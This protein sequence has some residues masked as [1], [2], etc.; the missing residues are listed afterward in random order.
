MQVSSPSK[1]FRVAADVGGTFTDIVAFD[2]ASGGAFYGKTLTTPSQLVDGIVTGVN[3]ARTSVDRARLF[4][5]GTTIAINTMLERSGARTALLTTRGFRD[6]YEIGRINRPQAYNLFF[7]KHQPLIKRSLRF[8]VNERMNARG[9]VLKALDEAELVATAAK[10]R[11]LEIEAVAIL[12]FH[13]YVNPAHELRAKQVIEQNCPGVFVSASHELS[14][15]YREFERTSTV[16]ANAYIGPRIKTYLGEI[17]ERFAAE[18]FDGS[19][20]V[21]QS[22]GGLFDVARAQREC[23]R[24]LESGPAAGVIGSKVVCDRLGLRN[25]IAFDMGG[26]TAKAGVVLAGEV[27]MAGNIMVGGYAEGL[28]IQIP[29]ID[30]QEVGTGG[31]S[32]ARI[33]EGGGLR[34]GPQSAGASPGPVC[35]DLGGTQPTVTDANLIL[36]R[37]S[38]G[39]FLGGEM[40][41]N[42]DKAKNALRS[43]IAEPMDISLTEAANGIIRI[44]ATTMSNIVTRVTT[45]RGLD[46]GDFAMVAYGGAG[47]LHA[48]IVAR[49]LKIPQVI[50]P[51]SPGHFSAYGMLMAD[52]R[53]D[54]VR[55]W[56]KPVNQLDFNEFEKHYADMESE[57]IRILERDI[58][59]RRRI[60]CTRAADMR[61][62][63]QE[64]P[65]TVELPGSLFSQRDR[66]ALKRLFD[67]VHMKRYDFNAPEESAEIVS[68]H[69]SVVGI[70]DKPV[71]KP[72]AGPGKKGGRR[73]AAK[74]AVRK[75]YL[76]ESSGYV[77]TPVY[78]RSELSAAQRI[79]GPALVQEYAST[80]VIFPGDSLKVSKFGDLVITIARS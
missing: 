23:I 26:T 8:E 73:P 75:V 24:M 7:R 48:C 51:P 10:L 20:F 27:M 47:P 15:E 31:G 70:M 35:Y 45:E 78:A 65:V 76:T 12:F 37:L 63:G 80:T 62:V 14:K 32:I 58:R 46:A 52:L 13:S 22:N 19:F 49:E 56:F 17:Q 16:A 25:A 40:R 79:A 29:L 61:Y 74:A 77:D 42:L 18:R 54:F 9:E 4:L 60:A 5:H 34:V 38:A 3:K 50:I 33:E 11:E 2:E 21:V 69:S 43:L 57:G 64:H 41:L 72:L 71:A 36:G 39:N 67:D 55:T 59:D 30:T 68:L 53:W 1:S 66:A 44:A 28:P 6:I